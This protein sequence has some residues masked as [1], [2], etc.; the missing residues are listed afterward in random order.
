VQIGVNGDRSQ[1]RFYNGF[2]EGDFATATGLKNLA[3]EK[4]H[5]IVARGIVLDFAGS[6]GVESMNKGDAPAWTTSRRRWTSRA[7]P[8]FEFK[9]GDAILF[10]YGW[11]SH[12][13]D[14]ATFNAGQPGI[15]M[16]VARWVAEEVKAGVTGGDTW[17]ATD[18]VPYADEPACAFCVQQYLQTRHASSIRRI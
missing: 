5:P 15:C 13:D 9:E 11:E 12:W 17:A 10:H 6:R 14:P 1:M 7:W 16:D 2:V 3:T 4:L 18:P 8:I